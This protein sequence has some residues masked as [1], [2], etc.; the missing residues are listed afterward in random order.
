[1]IMRLFAGGPQSE[2]LAL[3]HRLYGDGRLIEEDGDSQA[4]THVIGTLSWCDDYRAADSALTLTFADARRRGS[5]LTF[6]M[7]SQLRSRQRL[8]TGPVADAVADSRAA[9]E[10]WRGGPLAYLHPSGYCLVCALLE[11]GKPDEAEA[12]LGLGDSLPVAS[13]FF[14]AWRHAA[15]GHV[16]AHRGD[17]AGAL[18]AFLAAG[19]GLTELLMVNPALLAWRSEAGLA[20]RRLGRHDQARSLIAE[21]LALAERFGAP[22]AIGTARHAAGLLA[23]G[24]AAVELQRSAADTLGT[25]GARVE[26]ARALIDLGAAVRRAG[27][28]GEAR[29]TL[30]KALVLAEAAGAD[31]LA[32]R[33]RDELRLAGGRAGAPAG[34]PHDGLTPGERRVAELAA[35]GESNRQIADAL[36]VTVRAVEWHLGNTYRKLEIRGR[37]ELLGR[38]ADA[39]AGVV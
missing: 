17:D 37:G 38:L 9:V 11:Q 3:A 32:Q 26:H 1:M 18:E 16:A 13:G 7:A 25:C 39:P 6:A 33:A 4:L 31:V 20:A 15:A 2:V 22:R 24:E 23:R 8:W 5:V 10:V 28:P 14:A 30:R 21:E 12:A 19:R 36:F 29:G 34:T 35:A 27:R